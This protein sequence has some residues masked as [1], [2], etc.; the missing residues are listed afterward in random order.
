MKTVF[1][2]SIFLFLI[3][4]LIK[5]ILHI[6]LDNKHGRPLYFGRSYT[7]QYLLPYEEE[8]AVEYEQIKRLCNFFQKFTLPT[9]LILL[10]AALLNSIR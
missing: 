5:F 7:L 1:I 6:Y 9:F 8:V 3:P 4:Y 2:I 10:S